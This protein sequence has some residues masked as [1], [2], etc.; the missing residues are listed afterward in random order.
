MYVNSGSV[1]NY[2]VYILKTFA[3][4]FNFIWIF[5]YSHL[6]SPLVETKHK[7]CAKQVDENKFNC[8]VVFKCS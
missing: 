3:N 4:N 1:Y 8:F 2:A 7:V 5:T 6:S